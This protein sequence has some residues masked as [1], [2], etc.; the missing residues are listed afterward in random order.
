MGND[1]RG[2]PTDALEARRQAALAEYGVLDEH[3]ASRAELHALVALAAAASGV[4]KAAINLLTEDEQ[5]QIEA[6]GFEGGVTPRSESLCSVVVD[7]PEPVV[8]SDASQDPRFEDNP[9]VTGSAEV[10]FYATFQ[11]RTPAKV[12]VGTLCLFDSRPRQLTEQDRRLLQVLA[13]RVADVLELELQ[14]RRWQ[15]TVR[16]L[17][18]TNA[19]LVDFAATVSH[20][21]RGPLATVEMALGILEEQLEAASGPGATSGGAFG[22]RDLLARARRSTE[23]MSSTIGHLLAESRM[24]D[25][26]RVRPTSWRRVAADAVEDLGHE[27][28]GLQVTLD[29]ADALVCCRPVGLRLVL[30]NILSNAAR[31]AGPTDPRIEVGCRPVDGGGSEISVVDHGPGV[32]RA[33]RHRIFASRQ[34]GSDTA[35]DDEGHGL[36]LATAHRLLAEM[37]GRLEVRDTPGGGATFA[38]WLPDPAGA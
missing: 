24:S 12:A 25:T 18:R 36:G 26:D 29:P 31:Y 34:R 17:E 16:T 37:G 19:R 4:P 15:R 14:S 21:L 22:T 32:P 8:L 9:W 1:L 27:V 28:D 11:L 2:V 13:A 30:Q 7:E 33:D 38:L 3:H 35:G 6:V 23:R 10:R 20:D 5:H